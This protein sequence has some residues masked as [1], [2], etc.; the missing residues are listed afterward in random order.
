MP[1]GGRRRARLRQRRVSRIEY[2]RYRALEAALGETASEV[3]VPRA[4]AISSDR[5]I[6]LI[7]ALSGRRLALDLDGARETLRIVNRLRRSRVP[8]RIREMEGS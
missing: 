1:G 6:A 5:D 8:G 3:L 2:E 4:I 7:K